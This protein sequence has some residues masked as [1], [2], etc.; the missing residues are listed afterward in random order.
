MQ[1][2]IHSDYLAYLLQNST[3]S[4]WAEKVTPPRNDYKEDKNLYRTIVELYTAGDYKMLENALQNYSENIG[5]SDSFSNSNK[6]IS[7]TL[8][9][10]TALF[11]K[12]LNDKTTPQEQWDKILDKLLNT[13]IVAQ[14]TTKSAMIRGFIHSVQISPENSR[15][16]MA[17]IAHALGEE[18]ER[19]EAAALVKQL[20]DKTV[21][22]DTIHGIIESLIDD[23]FPSWEFMWKKDTG[24][25]NFG[26]Y[27]W[28]GQEVSTT[29]ALMIRQ[30]QDK[31]LDLYRVKYHRTVPVEF[32]QTTKIF[33][34]VRERTDPIRSFSWSPSLEASAF[35]RESQRL[36]T[37]PKV[38]RMYNIYYS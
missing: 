9:H 28:Q 18:K 21:D 20:I 37:L 6:I 38:Q 17:I 30:I 27:K 10:F 12:L 4:M 31:T 25:G 7:I 22:I 16:Y 2:D 33:L 14:G 26:G 11:E 3:P 29:W 34:F 8:Q 15:T 32:M 1:K 13:R 23:N 24:L 35:E 19:K 5:T 36:S